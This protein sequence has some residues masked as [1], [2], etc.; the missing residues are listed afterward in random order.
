M[1][2]ARILEENTRASWRSFR[3]GYANMAAFYREDEPDEPIA[4]PPRRKLRPVA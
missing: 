4:P 1:L 3:G 2:Q